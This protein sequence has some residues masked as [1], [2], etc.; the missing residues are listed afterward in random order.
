MSFTESQAGLYL[1]AAGATPA[2]STALAAALD[3]APVATVLLPAAD[4]ATLA[5]LVALAQSRGAAALVAD[6][7]RLAR[8]VGADGIHLSWTPDLAQ[9]YTAARAALGGE[10]IVGIE[11]GGSRHDAMVLGEAGA[12][13]IAFAPP[14]DAQDDG[15]RATLHA[16]LIA[17]WSELF[18][19]PCVAFGIEDP[20]A[21]ATL[22]SEGADF[23][24]VSLP[25]ASEPAAAA[26]LVTAIAAALPS[27]RTAGRASG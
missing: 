18:E 27:R 22:A 1:I 8:T 9:R 25:A 4:A 14:P 2:A 13:Y 11:A 7:A 3:A 23:I 10:S 26:S 16:D 5:P 24:A 20:E 21:A 6:D 17:W 15:E 12:D 19:V